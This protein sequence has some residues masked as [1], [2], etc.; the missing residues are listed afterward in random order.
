VDKKV[1][2]KNIDFKKLK[3]YNSTS[4]SF[5]SLFDENNVKVAKWLVFNVNFVYFLKNFRNL[6]YLFIKFSRKYLIPPAP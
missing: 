4:K 2:R 3:V 5:E 1:D 6:I